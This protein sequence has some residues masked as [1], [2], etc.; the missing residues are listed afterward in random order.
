[1]LS[2]LFATYC[3]YLSFSIDAK[4]VQYKVRRLLSLSNMCVILS[5]ILT[6]IYMMP[7]EGLLTEML[8]IKAIVWEVFIFWFI[9]YPNSIQKKYL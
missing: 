6:K 1:M 7:E 8:H 9:I 4:D 5:F 3:T 2:T